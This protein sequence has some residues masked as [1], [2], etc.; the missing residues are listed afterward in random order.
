MSSFCIQLCLVGQFCLATYVITYLHIARVCCGQVCI[1]VCAVTIAS[2]FW[3]SDTIFKWFFKS[4]PVLPGHVR[5]GTRS[6]PSVGTTIVKS[7][8]S[9]TYTPPFVV[10]LHS[11]LLNSNRATTYVYPAWFLASA[12]NWLSV[13]SVTQ[14][15]VLATYYLGWSYQGVLIGRGL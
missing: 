9:D 4:Y 8:W 2:T 15:L 10:R 5:T 7:T 11:V 3:V 13:R 6:W 12:A 14:P 1:A